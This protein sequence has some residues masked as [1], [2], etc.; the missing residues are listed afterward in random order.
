M[1]LKRVRGNGH[2]LTR[3]AQTFKIARLLLLHGAKM[4]HL[5]LAG[6]LRPRRA[7]EARSLACGR[8]A[9][10]QT[11]PRDLWGNITRGGAMSATCALHVTTTV[12]RTFRKGDELRTRREVSPR[13]TN[14]ASRRTGELVT[15]GVNADRRPAERVNASR[16]VSLSHHW[17]PFC[18]LRFLRVFSLKHV[19]SRLLKTRA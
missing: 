13:V 5:P 10:V 14:I 6:E 1:D 18:V 7:G 2:F 17:S 3:R 9:P 8:F 16:R 19:A 12:M 4:K 15:C 11:A